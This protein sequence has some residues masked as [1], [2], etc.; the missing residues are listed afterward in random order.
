MKRIEKWPTM[1]RSAAFEI[2]RVR[3]G[4]G[5]EADAALYEISISSEYP[6]S[7]WRG[8][9]IL[10]HKRGEVDLSRITDHAA[11]LLNHDHDRQ[12][13]VV[14][15]AWIDAEEKKL[16]G[17]IRFSRSALGQEVERDV[18][19]GIRRQISVGYA[20]EKVRLEKS[21]VIEGGDTVDTYR[22]T[23]W[24]PYEVSVVAVA[25]DPTVGL[26]RGEVGSGEFPVE[27]DD[28]EPVK[29][30]RKVT[31]EEIAAKE[32]ADREAAAAAAKMTATAVAERSEEVQ[33]IVEV[34]TA[35]GFAERAQDALKRG[36]TLDQ[37]KDEV[38]DLRR[39]EA[40]PIIPPTRDVAVEMP[41]KDRERYSYRKVLAELVRAAEGGEGLTGLEREVSEEVERTLPP[42]YV[43]QG[44]AFWPLA[45]GL[46]RR[47]KRAYPLD[48]ATA[49]EGGA[50]VFDVPG[51]FIEMLRARLAVNT[52]GARILTGLTGP[53]TFPR[54]TGAATAT[55]YVEE[56]AAVA[57]SMLATDTVPLVPKSLVATTGYTRQ[58]LAQASVGIE[59][60]VRDDLA[61]IHAQAID[62]AAL[63]G[64]GSGGV[65]KGVALQTGVASV[66]FG[67]GA[68]ANAV[69]SLVKLTA[70][71][72]AVGDAGADRGN[73]GY[74]TTPLVA[75][76]MKATAAFTNTGTP[77]W[78]GPFDG[79]MV[80]GYRAVASNNVGK[81]W[82]NGAPTGGAEH[83]MLYGN[84]LELLVGMWNAMEVV[85]DPYSLKK[86]AI[87]EVTTFQLVDATVRHG[88]S[89]ALGANV[90]P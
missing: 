67:A 45:L 73:L 42:G 50:T 52:L 69:P 86:R 18:V 78:E 38:L 66:D 61:M 90:I 39:K 25:A 85:V 71:Q 88:A 9:E 31:P 35:N 43:R 20:V 14:E 70:M 19:D 26:G 6:V 80:A 68:G 29:E 36:V 23:R 51:E 21:D 54:Q 30:E 24:Q 64:A 17:Q 82:L 33:R 75:A 79:G 53:V 55:W 63:I 2:E 77:L 84:W 76:T 56:A 16:R 1:R 11:L 13:G 62:I 83:G 47:E 89:F 87:I 3:D 81:V 32:K 60:M 15:K 44:G 5:G 48:S 10:G 4:D 41:E 57:D 74:I 34:Y 59:A 7:R 22:V 49:A 65:P 46:K 28:G 8:V 40:K 12:I 58:L 72:G 27:I 37:A